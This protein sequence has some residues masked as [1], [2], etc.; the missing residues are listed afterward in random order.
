MLS[1]PNFVALYFLPNLTLWHLSYWSF[2]SFFQLQRIK[3][4]HYFCSDLSDDFVTF[5]ISFL[6][7][8]LCKSIFWNSKAYMCFVK[9]CFIF[10]ELVTIS[11]SLIHISSYIFFFDTDTWLFCVHLFLMRFS[12][13]FYVLAF[14]CFFSRHFGL[15]EL[16]FFGV[17][18]EHFLL[19]FIFFVPSCLI[20]ASSSLKS[21]QMTV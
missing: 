14:V 4:F 1:S 9:I 10:I 7:S 8:F 17:F 11:S 6:S 15:F 2:F 5:S 12:S 16:H 13:L 21:K 20:I 19:H 3:S 18:C